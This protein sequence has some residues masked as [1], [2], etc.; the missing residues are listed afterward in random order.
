MRTVWRFLKKKKKKLSYDLATPL[1]DIHPEK[2]VIPKDTF[3]AMF[4][5]ALF[6]IANT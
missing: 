1:P 2:I 4:T 5:A 3:T 6:T